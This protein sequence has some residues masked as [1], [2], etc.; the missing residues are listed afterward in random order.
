MIPLQQIINSD[1]WTILHMA[2]LSKHMKVG[3]AYRLHQIHTLR[4]NDRHTV[5]KEQCTKL[6]LAVV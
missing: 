4:N 3:A 1:N 2:S 6:W 5:R